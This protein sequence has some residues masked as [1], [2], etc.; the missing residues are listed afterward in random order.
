MQR[1]LHVWRRCWRRA[2]FTS[3]QASIAI[4][5]PGQGTPPGTRRTRRSASLARRARAAGVRRRCPARAAVW[6]TAAGTR[7][8]SDAATPFAGLRTLTRRVSACDGRCH[9]LRRSDTRWRRRQVGVRVEAQLHRGVR[10]G[11]RTDAVVG[12]RRCWPCRRH[13]KGGISAS[14]PCMSI[15]VRARGASARRWPL[16]RAIP[17]RRRRRRRKHIVGIAQACENVWRGPAPVGNEAARGQAHAVRTAGPLRH[18]VAL[19]R[20]QL[21][22]GAARIASGQIECQLGEQRGMRPAL[23][24]P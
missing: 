8:R 15:A 13:G 17:Q 21:L 5:R 20:Q 3:V 2:R 1:V 16:C 23:H 24:A 6:P 12:W 4:A 10:D 9:G 7:G 11:Q 22:I 18:K 19:V 14:L